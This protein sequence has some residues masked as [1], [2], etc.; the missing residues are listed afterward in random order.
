[1]YQQKKQEILREIVEKYKKRPGVLGVAVFGSYVRGNFDE[2]SDIDVYVLQERPPRYARESWMLGGVRIDATI[3]GRKEAYRS[4]KGEN[5]SVR[6][7]FSHMLAYGKILYVK[8]GFLKE[9]Q[10]LAVKN[11]RERTVYTRDEMIMHLY[12]IEDFYGEVLRFFKQKD[13][14]SF[15]QSVMMLVNNA[16]ECFLKVNGEYVRRPNELAVIIKEKDP[17]FW[18]S[19]RRVF[20]SKDDSEKVKNLAGLV[21]KVKVLANGPLPEQWTVR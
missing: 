1:M 12:S 9:L 7:I 15:E 4:L 3:D 8:K 16:I 14:F 10:E 6:R 13:K 20:L 19:L 11:L 21:K 18:K 17:A 5:R 2:H